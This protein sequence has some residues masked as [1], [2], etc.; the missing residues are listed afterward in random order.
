MISSLI[1]SIVVIIITESIVLFFFLYRWICPLLLVLSAQQECRLYQI[2]LDLT[3]GCLLPP[4]QINECLEMLNTNGYISGIL[5]DTTSI[6]SHES[7]DL[8][9][10]ISTFQHIKSIYLLGRPSE[11]T[12]ERKK[13]I[14]RFATHCT[15]QQDEEQL[16]VQVLLDII[17]HCR[18]LGNKYTRSTDIDNAQKH[19]QRVIDMY[20]RL[21]NFI[22]AKKSMKL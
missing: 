1:V 3:D 2:L 19:F 18:M 14:A 11:S 13:Y 9:A 22:D 5:F 8:L 4:I 12:E 6:S 20:E 21:K 15:Y 16:A 10:K 17:I 7:D